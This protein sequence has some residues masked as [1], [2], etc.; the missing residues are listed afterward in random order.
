MEVSECF[1]CLAQCIKVDANKNSLLPKIIN[2]KS[3]TI[4]LKVTH[5]LLILRPVEGLPV[6]T[7]VIISAKFP[8]SGAS[9]PMNNSKTG[10]SE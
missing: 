9:F 7:R 6:G 3:Y 2:V 8:Y 1:H 5:Y 10:A 4:M